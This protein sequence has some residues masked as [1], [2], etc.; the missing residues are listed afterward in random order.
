MQQNREPASTSLLDG[1]FTNYTCYS[2]LSEEF[3]H[4]GCLQTYRML[5][6]LFDPTNIA[7]VSTPSRW[8]GFP[9]DKFLVESFCALEALP[10]LPVMELN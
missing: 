5:V 1:V 9:E 8:Q 6:Q 4:P 10:T 2:P 7:P 3:P